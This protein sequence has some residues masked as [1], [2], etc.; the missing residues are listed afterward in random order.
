[1]AH[2][3]VLSYIRVGTHHVWGS[4]PCVFLP[5][6]YCVT[7]AAM[8]VESTYPL[9]EGDRMQDSQLRKRGRD[10]WQPH[11]FKLI[12]SST[13]PQLTPQSMTVIVSA[14]H[15]SSPTRKKHFSVEAH[16][17]RRKSKWH[18]QEAGLQASLSNF[19]VWC[20]VVWEKPASHSGRAKFCIEARTCASSLEWRRMNKWTFSW[21]FCLFLLCMTWR[22]AELVIAWTYIID[23]FVIWKKVWIGDLDSTTGRLWNQKGRGRSGAAPFFLQFFLMCPLPPHFFPLIPR[24]QQKLIQAAMELFACLRIPFHGECCGHYQKFVL[25]KTIFQGPVPTSMVCT[26]HDMR[27]SCSVPRRLAHRHLLPPIACPHCLRTMCL[28][29]HVLG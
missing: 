17:G 8:T 15:C 26:E 23:W 14:H 25:E 18:P 22:G 13:K 27:S 1:M 7:D 28:W 19:A 11:Y 12:I 2:C 6:V 3:L 20:S 9:T 24:S 16:W 21:I 10:T 29:D 4:I 5:L